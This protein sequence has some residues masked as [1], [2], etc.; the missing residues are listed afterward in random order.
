MRLLNFLKITVYLNCLTPINF[1][2]DLL[3]LECSALN[4][5]NIVQAFYLLCK[6]II[7][8]IEEGVIVLDDNPLKKLVKPSIEEENQSEDASKSRCASC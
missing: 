4:G 5:E 7:Q 2:I 1:N 6:N 8:K 3:I